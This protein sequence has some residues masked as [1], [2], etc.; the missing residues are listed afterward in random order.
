MNW[1]ITCLG[2]LDVDIWYLALHAR[3]EQQQRLFHTFSQKGTSDFLVATVARW[4]EHEKMLV[5]LEQKCQ[6]HRQAVEPIG[7]RQ[8][9]EFQKQIFQEI[10][11]LEGRL[12]ADQMELLGK[13]HSLERTYKDRRYAKMEEGREAFCST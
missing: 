4:D 5:S 3:G 10:K 12:S 1:N 13:K 11:E 6:E 2:E 9:E 7:E 8:S